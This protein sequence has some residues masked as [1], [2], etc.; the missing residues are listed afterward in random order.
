MTILAVLGLIANSSIAIVASSRLV[1]AVA[2]DGVLP[3]SA[4]VGQVT[5]DGRPKKCVYLSIRSSVLRDDC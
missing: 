3:G 2:R 1:F 5:E 4:W